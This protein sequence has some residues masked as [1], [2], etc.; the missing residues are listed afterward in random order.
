MIE[1]IVLDNHVIKYQ[2]TFKNNKNTYFL[3]KRI[4]YIQINASKHQT[5][6]GI[7]NFIKNN[8]ETFIKK[9]EKTK[10]SIRDNSYYYLLGT[11]YKKE[12]NSDSDELALD[13]VNYVIKEPNVSTEQLMEL[14]SQNG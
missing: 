10:L 7:L 4:G 5:H 2:I 1:E 12:I 9:Y 14:Y 8:K 13:H 6:K 11:K 3:F